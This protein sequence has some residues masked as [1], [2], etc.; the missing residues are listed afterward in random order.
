MSSQDFVNPEE[1]YYTGP[2]KL[3]V[4]TDIDFSNI[5]ESAKVEEGEIT[6]FSG[7]LRQVE[8]GVQFYSFDEP[9]T[10][11]YEFIVAIRDLNGSP[12]WL[13]DDYRESA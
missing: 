1:L 2:F 5:P 4:T 11:G 6:I 12:I 9:F 3:T 7:F 10:L 8:E 13:N